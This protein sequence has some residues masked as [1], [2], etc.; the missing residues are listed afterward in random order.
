[1]LFLK[2]LFRPPRFQAEGRALYRQ[3]AV[4]ARLPVFYMSYGVPDTI[5]GRFEMLCLHAYALFHSLKGRGADADA[6]GQA[7]YDA[8]FADLDGSLREMGVADLGVGK[9]IKAMT[10]ALNGRIHAF[11]RAFA[12]DG[13]A[14]DEAIRRNVY[15]TVT[16]TDGHVQAMADYLRRTRVALAGTSLADLCAARLSLPAP[17][18]REGAHASR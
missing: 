17:A 3:M 14:L 18:L 13:L 16:P 9:R 4:Q 5:D 12:A 6:L 7:T 8:M 1:M 11:D 2:R 10:E 15:G